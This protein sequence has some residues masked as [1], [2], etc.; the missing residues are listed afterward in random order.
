MTHSDDERASAKDPQRVIDPVG[1]EPGT[2]AGNPVT[3]A[4]GRERPAAQP[5]GQTGV[6]A[7]KRGQTRWLVAAVVAVAVLLLLFALL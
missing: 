6:P 5:A 2:A 4:G 1:T 7:P 3:G